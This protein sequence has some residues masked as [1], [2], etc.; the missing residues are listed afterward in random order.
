MGV[1][2]KI[3]VGFVGAVVVGFGL[4]IYKAKR[5][6]E[7]WKKE[8][9]ER[10]RVWDELSEVAKD[11]EREAM[12]ATLREEWDQIFQRLRGKKLRNARFHCETC[13]SAKEPL[14]VSWILAPDREQ[15]P[16]ELPPYLGCWVRAEVFDDE[17]WTVHVGI[18][19]WNTNQGVW[20]LHIPRR[21]EK[22]KAF[23]N[24]K[25]ECRMCGEGKPEAH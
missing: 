15:Y 5:D 7:R 6:E 18:E 13:G 21:W 10:R 16:F 17:G 25:V 8:R 1:D 14:S 19:S 20:K 24:L 2:E 3:G 23:Q 4:L 22:Y 12:A 9:E 11:E